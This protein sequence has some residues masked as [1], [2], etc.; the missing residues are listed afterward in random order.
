VRIGDFGSCRPGPDAQG[1]GG[2]HLRADLV[3]TEVYRPLHLFH[4]ARSLV[5]A[6]FGFD[7]WAFGCVVFDVAQ[8]SIRFQKKKRSGKALRLFSGLPLS[9]DMKMVLRARNQRL[10]RFV[11]PPVVSVVLQC[12]PENAEMRGSQASAELVLACEQLAGS[13]Q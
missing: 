10:L 11:S 3:N 6:Q 12:Q 13:A 4:S 2:E 1:M 8:G 9:D 7:R 5:R